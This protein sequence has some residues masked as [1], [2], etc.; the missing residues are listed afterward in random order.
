M[1]GQVVFSYFEGGLALFCIRKE[2]KWYN[3][4]VIIIKRRT[5]GY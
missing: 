4:L 2:K 5:L 1:K 3:F